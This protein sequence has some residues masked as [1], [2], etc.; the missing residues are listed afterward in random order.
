MGAAATIF[1][2]EARAIGDPAEVR[3][4]AVNDVVTTESW[5]SPEHIMEVHTDGFA[6]GDAY[7]DQ[8]VFLCAISSFIGGDSFLVD[9]YA[10]LDGLAE[11][12]DGAILVKDM[13]SVPIDQ[14]EPG[15]QEAIS[16]LVGRT[17]TG[18]R[19]C[20]RSPGQ[21][22]WQGSGT[23]DRDHEMIG[24][25]DDLCRHAGALAP[26]FKLQAGEAL[27]VDNYRIVHGR[28]PY[29]DIDR[30]MWRVWVWTTS[31]LAVP[32]GGATSDTRNASPSH[33]ANS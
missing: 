26:R 23:P 31:A 9:C 18:R 2:A 13:E 4:S 32:I 10:L 15:M 21:K 22:P 17:A 24:V 7:P 20:R 28:D 27:V 25:W 14:S 5:P 19:M 1:A 16:P 11:T 29:E 6:Y 3:A 33:L 30:L 8:F 12:P